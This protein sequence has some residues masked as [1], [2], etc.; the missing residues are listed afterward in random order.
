MVHSK[1]HMP[2]PLAGV[3][4]IR[5]FSHEI[6]SIT[7]TPAIEIIDKNDIIVLA[8]DV[9]QAKEDYCIQCIRY[10]LCKKQFTFL[11]YY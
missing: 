2:V 7:I 11:H 6:T 4:L 9:C 1:N 10:S 8:V 5:T 3:N